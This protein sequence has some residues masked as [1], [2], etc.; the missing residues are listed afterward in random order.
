M[1][2]K[3]KKTKEVKV[4]AP[5]AD[6]AVQKEVVNDA[7]SNGQ[8]MIAKAIAKYLRISPKKLRRIA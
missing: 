3:T 6:A 5:K 1:V 4:K 8:P 2:T 7:S